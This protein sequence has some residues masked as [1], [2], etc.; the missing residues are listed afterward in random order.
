MGFL[1]MLHR[2]IHCHNQSRFI[3]GQY[4]VNHRFKH[5]SSFQCTNPI[6]SMLPCH[7]SARD[8]S[9]DMPSPVPGHTS[10]TVLPHP[11]NH[12]REVLQALPGIDSS[13][14]ED[15]SWSDSVFCRRVIDEAPQ[16]PLRIRRMFLHPR[17][18]T[19][20][21]RKYPFNL[22]SVSCVSLPCG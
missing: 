6:C 22:L 21:F 16:T 4:P 20:R 14:P 12:S 8:P 5:S 18:H 1:C 17:I 15:A 2:L 3:R 11:R 10:D 7:S 13:L 9:D 19:L